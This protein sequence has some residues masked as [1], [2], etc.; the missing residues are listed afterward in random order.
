MTKRH[1]RTLDS[2]VSKHTTEY[3]ITQQKRSGH[4]CIIIKHAGKTR[5]LFASS[6]PSDHRVIKNLESDL[7]RALR[8]ME[9]D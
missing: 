1:I 4:Y 9:E 2:M 3:E 8:Q 6:T 5:K 7:K